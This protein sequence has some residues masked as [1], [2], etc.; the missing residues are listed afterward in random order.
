MKRVITFFLFL[1][2]AARAQADVDT[3]EG[4]FH[5]T[6]TD[7]SIQVGKSEVW[8]LSRR[9]SSRSNAIGIFG[10]GWCSDLDRQ[11]IVVDSDHMIFK[12]CDQV[13]HYRNSSRFPAAVPPAALVADG[14][15]VSQVARLADGSLRRTAGFLSEIYNSKGQ[16]QSMQMAPGREI[17]ILRTAEG[18]PLE[19]LFASGIR[20]GLRFDRSRV[21]SLVGPLGQEVS[22]LYQGSLLQEVRLPGG[23]LIR[24]RY[25]DNQNLS[26]ILATGQP[27]ITVTYDPKLDLVT[28]LKASKKYFAHVKSISK[29]AVNED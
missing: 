15:S 25:D 17:K 9:Y 27:P 13:I 14:D 23:T 29:G 8:K 22:Y 11:L 10:L 1:I 2:A 5:T 20:I 26:Q 12:N 28:S 3:K 21:Q 16:M 7:L 4:A 24:M 18:L 19:I 6:Q